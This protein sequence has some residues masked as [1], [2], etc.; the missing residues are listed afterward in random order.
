MRIGLKSAVVL[1]LAG[2]AYGIVL[3]WAATPVATYRSVIGNLHF[4]LREGDAA[5]AE[6]ALE[7]CVP[8]GEKTYLTRSQLADL[9]KALI[10]ASIEHV[11]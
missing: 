8:F 5:S 11:K 10:A 4:L 9:D 7:R 1:F 2:L 3:M 6:R